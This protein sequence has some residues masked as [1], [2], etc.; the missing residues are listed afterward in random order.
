MNIEDEWEL[1]SEAQNSVPASLPLLSRALGL[2]LNEAWLDNDISGMIEREGDRFRITLNASDSSNRK[3]F[4]LAHELG[5]YMLHRHLIGDGLDD[6]R[7]YRSTCAG[8]YHNTRIGPK[9]ER[10]AN[11]FAALLLMPTKAINKEWAEL[12]PDVPAMAKRFGV[13]EQAM[14][15]RLGDRLKAR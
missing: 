10:E 15:I 5:H 4:T 8:K 14:T 7:A 12:K 2:R 6:D 11:R 9:E 1:I 3:R 13:S